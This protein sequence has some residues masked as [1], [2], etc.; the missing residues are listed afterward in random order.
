MT[1]KI[2]L[3][4]IIYKSDFL[5]KD[6]DLSPNDI[7]L[8]NNLI[9]TPITLYSLY[10]KNIKLSFIFLYLRAYLDG[11]DGYI[12]RKYKKY[13]K[14]GEIYDHVSDSIYSGF[15]MLFCLD[16][17]TQNKIKYCISY[18]TAITVMI[19]NFDNN[20]KHI[21]EKIMGA[22][23]SDN[24][25][26]TMINFIPL[27]FITKKINFKNIYL[28]SLENKILLKNILSLKK[29]KYSINI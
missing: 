19:C 25:Y 15:I 11:V 9:V 23:G 14:L 1:D 21:S 4:P 7:T 18:M 29:D 22:G 5:Y 3:Y 16:Q 13:S 2:I 6:Y 28:K 26:S 12:A 17:I 24:T 10:K 20:H 27:I 8:I